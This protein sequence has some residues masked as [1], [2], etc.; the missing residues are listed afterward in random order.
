MGVETSEFDHRG[1]QLLYWKVVQESFAAA[2][3]GSLSTNSEI[4]YINIACKHLPCIV[5]YWVS[6]IN[7]YDNLEI[8]TTSTSI[9]VSIPAQE[10]PKWGILKN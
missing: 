3:Y 5:K 2:T 9:G 7:K 10:E 1:T 6:E 4:K 8:W